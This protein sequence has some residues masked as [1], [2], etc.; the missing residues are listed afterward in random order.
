MSLL[1]K[2]RS[3]V[4]SEDSL[5]HIKP[6]HF[7]VIIRTLKVYKKN[8]E[9]LQK[10]TSIWEVL[11]AY[12]CT[13]IYDEEGIKSLRLR[14]DEW[15]ISLMVFFSVLARHVEPGG[16]IRIIDENKKNYWIYRFTGFSLKRN[17]LISRRIDS[18]Q[19]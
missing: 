4:Y 11:R 6:D 19:L 16:Y 5:V 1:K 7:P 2:T 8:N 15:D 17:N 3:T 18:R 14:A 13:A 12:N 9:E 10:A